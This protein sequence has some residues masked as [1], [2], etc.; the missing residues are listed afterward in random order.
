MKSCVFSWFKSGG[1]LIL[2]VHTFQTRYAFRRCLIGTVT[3]SRFATAMSFQAGWSLCSVR[4]AYS[5]HLSLPLLHS[6]PHL[7]TAARGRKKNSHSPWSFRFLSRNTGCNRY[8]YLRRLCRYWKQDGK[9]VHWTSILFLRSSCDKGAGVRWTVLLSV[10]LSHLL[11]ADAL[12]DVSQVVLS[13]SYSRTVHSDRCFIPLSFSQMILCRWHLHPKDVTVLQ[14]AGY[15]VRCCEAYDGIYRFL[16]AFEERLVPFVLCGLCISRSGGIPH[17]N[18]AVE[19]L[20]NIMDITAQVY[21]RAERMPVSLLSVLVV[22]HWVVYCR[23]PVQQSTP[24]QKV[25]LATGVD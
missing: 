9:M 21:L 1:A 13:M 14:N 20:E 18:L 24:T 7:Q 15:T 19:G 10:V 12:R 2:F 25:I 5:L 6:E 8:L 22:G 4:Y 23:R 11:V 17:L 16:W 3:S